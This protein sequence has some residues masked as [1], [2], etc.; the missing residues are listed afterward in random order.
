MTRVLAPPPDGPLER[1]ETPTFSIVIAAFDVADVIGEAIESVLRQTLRPHEIVVCDDGSS[2]DIAGSLEP[3]RDRIVFLRKEH[4][5]EASAKN[6]AAAAASGDFVVI[7]D[8]DDVFLP[9]RLEA[10]AELAAARPDLDILTTDAFLTVGGAPVRRCYG[11]GWPFPVAEQRREILRRNF[12]FGHAAVRRELLLADGGFDTSILWTTDWDRWL[13]LILTGSRVGA[14]AEPLALYRLRETSLSAR[15]ADLTRGKIMTLEKARRN[16][17]LRPEERPVVDAALAG[18]RRELALAELRRALLAREPGTRARALQLAV[19]PVLAP[20]ERAEAAAAALAPAASAQLLRARERRYW[21]GAGGIR[22]RRRTAGTAPRLRVAVYTDA[23]EVGGAERSA[24]N[25]VAALA[26]EI[27]VAVVCVDAAV[28]GAIAAGRAQ[29]RVVALPFVRSRHD[30]RAILAHLRVFAA[31]RPDV[32]HVN[33]ISPWSC[34]MA[35][36]LALLVPRIRVVAVEQLPTP[37]PSPGRRRLKRLTAARLAGH[38]AV[39]ERSARELE[40]TIGLVPG[41]VRTIYNGVADTDPGA[42]ELPLPAGATIGAVGRLEY[43]KGLDVLLRA[44]AQL[45]DTTLAILGDG[46]E[47]PRLE[48]LATELGVAAR[49]L[50]LGWSDD[51]RAHLRSFDVLALPSRFEG[52]PLAV[53]EAM[54]AELPVVAS[55]VGSVAEAVLDGET[56]LLVPAD[57]PA[58]L[59]A[60]LG[61]LLADP[62]RRRRMGERGRAHALEHFTAEAMARQFEQLYAEIRA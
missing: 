2:D 58:A 9:T 55:D 62:H 57:D 33:L 61:A 29:A 43:Q 37:P 54:L 52:F 34:Q 27:E 48:A 20:R 22:V 42:A 53:V 50:W 44:L 3:Y 11:G 19:A 38:V 21:T 5:G 1:G 18:Y 4:G 14:V 51:P 40:R 31:L 35:I 56:G 23:F 17:A 46:S 28:G 39:G 36:A 13:R 8:A 59:A 12:V 7:L 24:A 15:R 30:V 41:S 45:P 47:R 16:P 6:V 26:P 25:L 49:V 10:L 60:A 32:L